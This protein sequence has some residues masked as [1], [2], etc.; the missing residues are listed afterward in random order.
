MSTD[1]R[2]YIVLTAGLIAGM[3]ADGYSYRLVTK[4][5]GGRLPSFDDFQPTIVTQLV[6]AILRYPRSL[7]PG[8]QHLFR[9]GNP[10]A[11]RMLEKTI[12]FPLLEVIYVVLVL[13][14]F[15]RWGFNLQFF[16]NV[17]LQLLVITIAL[18]CNR[19]MMIPNILVMPGIAVGIGLSLI[20]PDVDFQD[21]I[22]GALVGGGVFFAIALLAPGGMGMGSVKMMAMIGS[23]LGWRLVIVSMLVAFLAGSAIG[24]ALMFAGKANRKTNISFGEFQALGAIVALYWGEWIFSEYADLFN[25]G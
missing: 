23:F 5:F 21:A 13:I 24:L 16:S 9:S 10:L 20:R 17:I 7:I 14:S 18:I 8:H 6:T 3:I 1:Y 19:S 4:K 25:S 22:L 2:I 15:S 12:L 11:K